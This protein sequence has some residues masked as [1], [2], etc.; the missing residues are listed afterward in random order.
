MPGSPP[1]SMA[2]PAT[3]H[4]LEWADNPDWAY[5]GGGNDRIVGGVERPV[6]CNTP[7]RLGDEIVLVPRTEERAGA[8]D[9]RA[10]AGGSDAR[11]SG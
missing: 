8:D 9:Q 1:T 6:L 7:E 11:L 4:P 5:G 2:D 3:I 10:A